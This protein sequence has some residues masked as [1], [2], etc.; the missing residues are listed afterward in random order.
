MTVY[1]GSRPSW[2]VF[3]LE[4]VPSAVGSLAR[5]AGCSHVKIS[6]RGTSTGAAGLQWRLVAE[7]AHVHHQR[8]SQG[9]RGPDG[10]AN[11]AFCKFSVEN[12]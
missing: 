12:Y 1:L 9:R 8:L 5:D 7:A 10:A 3:F 6:T 2:R 4:T 11:G